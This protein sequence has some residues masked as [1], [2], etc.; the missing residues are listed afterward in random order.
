MFN[1]LPTA[2]KLALRREYRMRLAIVALSMFLFTLLAAFLLMIPSYVLTVSK[3]NFVKQNQNLLGQE[4]NEADKAYSRDLAKIRDELA[5]LTPK[6]G[7]L[8]LSTF[9]S[10]LIADRNSDIKINSI[11]ITPIEGNKSSI[12]IAG[13]AG[14]RVS[15][16]DFTKAIETERGVSD[17]N[18]P[19][20]NFAKEADIEFAIT[21]KGPA[22]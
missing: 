11:V 12:L 16:L 3:E 19:V 2:E 7:S 5:A 4:L 21:V 14:K 6:S 17:V 15:L 9:I 18:T 8:K 1:L 10:D 13:L 20:S 22:F